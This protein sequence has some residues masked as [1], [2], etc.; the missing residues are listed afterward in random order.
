MDVT[1]DGAVGTR[2]LDC[3]DA[4][5]TVDANGVEFSRA[6]DATRCSLTAPEK[7]RNVQSVRHVIEAG[8][9]I[10]FKRKSGR[11]EVLVMGSVLANAG[12]VDAA[13]LR[14][15]PALALPRHDLSRPG[16][17]HRH[18]KDVTK[19]GVEDLRV[20]FR[21]RDTGLTRDDTTACLTGI[22]R[23]TAFRHCGELRSRRSRENMGVDA[24]VG[25]L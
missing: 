13:S 25:R 20:H 22:A 8:G 2:Q 9:P 1:A 21:L 15:G 23:G 19:D 3:F 11:I 5:T 4:T 17:E 12:D 7:C 16:V 10:R 18:R 14:L 24:R 6:W